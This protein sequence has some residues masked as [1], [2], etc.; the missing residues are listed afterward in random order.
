MTKRRLGV[1]ALGV[2]LL[3]ASA[4]ATICVPIEYHDV[5]SMIRNSVSFAV[6]ALLPGIIGWG[7]LKRRE[8]FRR[9]GVVLFSI[10]G[11]LFI[12]LGF[13]WLGLSLRLYRS[14]LLG[15]VFGLVA[16]YLHSEQ[17]RR[18]FSSESEGWWPSKPR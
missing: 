9:I 2:C 12:A 3:T 10:L 14:L 4:P 5:Q 8:L 13:A 6:L 11:L 7:L 15:T 17:V 18:E 16:A 1:T